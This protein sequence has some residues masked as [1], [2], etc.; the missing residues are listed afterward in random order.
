MQIK[1][2]A[3]SLSVLAWSAMLASPV[4][5]QQ[6]E[7]SAEDDLLRSIVVTADRKDADRAGGSVQR[8]DDEHMRI[9]S[10]SDIGR[11]LRQVPGVSIQEE[12]GLGLRP[13]IG[14]RGSGTDRSARIVVMEDGILAAPAPYAA[15]AAYYFPRVARMSGIEIAKGPAAIKYGP[16]TIGGALGLFST[17]ISD[18][19]VGEAS[20]Q[21]EMLAGNFGGRRIHGALGGWQA[22]GSGVEAGAMVEGLSS[23]RTASN[24]S[25]AVARPDFGSTISS[26]RPVCA[27]ATDGISSSSNTRPM[28]N[29][30][31]KPISAC[32]WRT[33]RRRPTDATMPA[34]AT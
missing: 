27:P 5:A 15:P 21:A 23:V 17:P 18:K 22:L 11:V 12:D 19:P 20:G 14:I 33:S 9:F 30:A 26:P 6:V 29:A 10:Y 31:T 1:L 4:V 32:R 25:T 7:R 13:N 16:S 28:T 34:S 24:G 3:V 2:R 8:L